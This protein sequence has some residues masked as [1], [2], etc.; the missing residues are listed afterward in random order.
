MVSAIRW[1]V[2]SGP[3]RA[4]VRDKPASSA[5]SR[6]S[7][8]PQGVSVLFVL[9]R[10]ARS[11]LSTRWSIWNSPS[12]WSR[13]SVPTSN[14]SQLESTSAPGDHPQLFTIAYRVDVADKHMRVFVRHQGDQTRDVDALHFIR[15]D[16]SSSLP[17]S[18]TQACR[19][20][21]SRAAPKVIMTMST[22]TDFLNIAKLP[23]AAVPCL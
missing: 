21:V 5:R 15:L 8:R 13:P 19:G 3:R 11:C 16:V 23:A 4:L 22:V 1:M 14:L 6:A 9:K 2:V 10:G 18:R 17:R 12:A 20:Q 7:S